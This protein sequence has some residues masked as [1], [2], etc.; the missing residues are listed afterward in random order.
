M[1]ANLPRFEIKDPEVSI[2]RG[3]GSSPARS[4]HHVLEMPMKFEVTQDHID[5]G[6]AMNV[7]EL[8][9]QIGRAHV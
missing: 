3:A 2:H 7:Q 8:E 5:R 1:T 4:N 6:E 9:A